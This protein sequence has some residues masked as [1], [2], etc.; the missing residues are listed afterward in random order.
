MINSFFRLTP[1]HPPVRPHARQHQS[2]SRLTPARLPPAGINRL[3]ACSPSSLVRNRIIAFL[4]AFNH[5]Y[6]SPSITCTACLQSPLRLTFNH[7][8]GSPS[9]TFTA[10][11]L[12]P[13]CYPLN[14]LSTHL[15]ARSQSP[16]YSPLNAFMPALN[17]LPARPYLSSC[18]P[19]IAFLLALNR[20]PSLPQMLALFTCLPALNRL[21][22]RSQLP[23]CSPSITFL[24]ALNRLPDRPQL[25]F[26]SPTIAFPF[27]LSR[28]PAR[29]QSPSRLSSIA[30]SPSTQVP[31]TLILISPSISPPDYFHSHI[32]FFQPSRLFPFPYPLLTVLLT[33]HFFVSPLHP[34]TIISFQYSL[35][36]SGKTITF[37]HSI[38]PALP[39][40]PIFIS[41]SPSPPDQPL[42]HI[43]FSQPF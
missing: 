19:S 3:S 27:A 1:A 42:S 11:L 18:P 12:S 16:S 2:P 34:I 30:C 8:Y 7:L 40:T 29:P 21:R 33:N 41:A 6:G 23:S 10:R 20:F 13:S 37:P 15:P 9:I 24:L 39:I 4:L 25:P 43:P 22:E 5:L 26:C 31:T 28:H 36:Q 35:L 32:P 17:R 14:A 38:L